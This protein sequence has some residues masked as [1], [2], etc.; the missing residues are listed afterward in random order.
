[1]HQH[2]FDALM[3]LAFNTGG[4]PSN[5]GESLVCAAY[6]C[7]WQVSENNQ[8][9]TEQTERGNNMACFR[10]L[11]L[12]GTYFLSISAWAALPAG[13]WKFEGSADY[14]GRT[15]VNKA[16]QFA[17]IVTSNDQVNFSETC[18]VSLSPGK[19]F[20]SDV[21]QSLTKQGITEKHVD[22]FLVKHFKLSLVSTKILYSL[23]PST[24][25][26]P[27][28]LE[29][30]VVN[31]RILVPVGVT[32]YVY[33]RTKPEVVVAAPAGSLPTAA[34]SLG[35]KVTPLPIVYRRYSASCF[36]KIRDGKGRPHT[37]DKCAPDFFPY[38][39]DPRSTDPI[40]K[41]V[42]NHDY[43]TYRYTQL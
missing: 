10:F 32:F 38:V 30:F 37:T 25:C 28:A 24:N 33:A 20:F 39:A 3:S 23:G 36:S 35:Y 7:Q 9:V 42:G 16:P 1:L 27:Q 29:F 6:V 19:Y 4:L 12:L 8:L 22:A 5:I 21:F 2:E 13:T 18:K 11:M 41:L 43:T 17:T 15:P 40:M 26:D 14:F 34:T 31:D